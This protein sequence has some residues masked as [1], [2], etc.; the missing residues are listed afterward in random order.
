[1]LDRPHRLRDEDFHYGCLKLRRDVRTRRIKDTG[2]KLQEHT[3][4]PPPKHTQSSRKRTK[5]S[6]DSP[7]RP[8]CQPVPNT[9]PNP[10]HPNSQPVHPNNQP[11]ENA[12]ERPKDHPKEKD[13]GPQARKKR[14]NLCVFP[15][16]FI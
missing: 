1:M 15:L 14:Q 7:G 4:P 6:Q 5:Y 3:S 11:S 16:S 13:S 8:H 12:I 9:N 10:V 2:L